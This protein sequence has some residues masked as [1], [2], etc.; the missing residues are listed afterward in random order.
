MGRGKGKGSIMAVRA[1]RNNSMVRVRDNTT[2]LLLR[3]ARPI[4]VN[5]MPT[6]AQDTRVKDTPTQTIRTPRSRR[7]SRNTCR[8]SCGNSR[9]RVVSSCKVHRWMTNRTAV[10][11]RGGVGRA[12]TVLV[13][14]GGLVWISIWIR[15]SAYGIYSRRGVASKRRRC[16]N[17][18]LQR[19]G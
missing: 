9:G 8:V 12:R 7:R 1:T 11:C 17:R 14:W 2:P 3:T 16:S 10:S 13:D 15:D 19:G 5:S 6:T 18:Q 4:R